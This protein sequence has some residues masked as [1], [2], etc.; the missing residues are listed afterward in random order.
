M[1]QPTDA[2]LEKLFAD[3]NT[4]WPRNQGAA[5]R[6]VYNFGFEAA[7]R[8][9]RSETEANDPIP[10]RLSCPECGELHIDEGEFETRAHHTHAC[11]HCGAV[12]RPAIVCTVG[13]RFL[14]GFKN[15]PPPTYGV[16]RTSTRKCDHPWHQ[17]LDPSCPCPLCKRWSRG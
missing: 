17:K 11:Q 14:P 15:V 4:V 8:K 12:W 2:E 7:L 10:M 13:V 1:T 3:A 9:A 16:I 6:N 5:L